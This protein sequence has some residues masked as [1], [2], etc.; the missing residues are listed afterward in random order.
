[1]PCAPTFNGSKTTL[2]QIGMEALEMEIHVPLI[3]N[4]SSISIK[5][6]ESQ[7]HPAFGEGLLILGLWHPDRIYE[8]SLNQPGF[9]Q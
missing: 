3:I 8:T 5:R 4:D 9:Y 6:S 7:Y 2:R 1:M